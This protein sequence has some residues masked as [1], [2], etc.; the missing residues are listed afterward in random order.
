MFAKRIKLLEKLICCADRAGIAKY[1]FISFGTL[2]GAVRPTLRRPQ[3]GP[4]HY[5]RGIMQH[6]T[7]MDVGFQADK[8]NPILREEYY[9]YCHEAGMINSWEKPATRIRR[10]QDN[11]DILWF[12]A[13]L[14]KEKCCQWFFFEHQNRMV[15]TKG[16]DWTKDR[17]FPI[18]KY[19]RKEG[20]QALCL[21]APARYFDELMPINFEGIT[22][23]VPVQSGSLLDW[24]YPG[25]AVPKIG[26]SSAK[27]VVLIIEKWDNQR[28]WKWI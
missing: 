27:K 3:D 6:D 22:V 1:Q 26:G 4:P 15:H 25:W 2:L 14:N 9:H 28:S 17:K 13:K 24:W 23:N 19:P 16:D 18:K 20:S 21:G 7:D 11:N 8:F 5:S 10:R 12:S